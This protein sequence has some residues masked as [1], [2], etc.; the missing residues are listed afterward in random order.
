MRN[1]TADRH[2]SAV[3]HA[4]RRNAHQGAVALRQRTRRLQ[5]TEIG[6]GLSQGP[7]PVPCSS[8]VPADNEFL[9]VLH[10]HCKFEQVDMG[11]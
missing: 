11:N 5:R 6:I 7:G 9:F 1:A 3:N 4:E 10:W 8:T 2:V